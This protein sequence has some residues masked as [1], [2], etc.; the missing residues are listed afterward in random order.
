MHRQNKSTTAGRYHLLAGPG[1]G[2]KAMRDLHAIY[3]DCLERIERSPG[4]QTPLESEWKLARRF[5]VSRAAARRVMQ[6]LVREGLAR[7]I[8]GK[9]YVSRPPQRNAPRGSVRVG[10]VFEQST[11]DRSGQQNRILVSLVEALRRR[12][13]NAVLIGLRAGDDRSAIALRAQAEPVDAYLLYSLPPVVQSQFAARN[14]PAVVFGNTYADL[15]LPSVCLDE[16]SI[17]RQLCEDLLSAGHHCIALVQERSQNLGAER[18]RVGFVYAHHA[19]RQRFSSDRIVLVDRQRGGRSAA[20]AQLDMLKPT[21]MLVQNSELL[22][23]LWE[24]A[25]AAQ[26]VRMERTSMVVMASSAA[27]PLPIARLRTL[28][29]DLDAAARVVA[30]LLRD[31]LRARRPG[32]N[33]H[34]I[35]WE[36]ED[37]V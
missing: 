6:R 14:K 24:K 8:R 37:R 19:R 4:V 18:S 25:S 21:A 28:R 17:T 34:V 15:A 7:S 33:H 16:L 35:P 26:R 22:Q 20:L 12:N 23:W 27:H 36:L 32:A 31:T 9:G 3:R 11:G 30:R 13:L 2:R 29:A 1:D 5:G 10:I